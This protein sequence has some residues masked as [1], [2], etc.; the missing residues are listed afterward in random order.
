MQTSRFDKAFVTHCDEN[1]I[2]I[3]D[4]M[5]STVKEYSNIPFIVYV[6]NSDKPVPNADKVVRLNCDIREGKQFIDAA[7]G[8]SIYVDRSSERVYD[9]I[10]KKPTVLIHALENFADHVVYI[11]GDSI[12]TPRIED[13]FGWTNDDYPMLT[14]S[15]DEFMMWGGKGNPFHHRYENSFDVEYSLETP[16][17]NLLN[18]DQKIN[19]W[20]GSNSYVQTGYISSVKSNLPFL[21]EWESLCNLEEIVNNC[22][23]YAPFHEETIVNVLLWKYQYK[24]RMP[25]V[26]V[27]AHSPERIDKTYLAPWHEWEHDDITL[28]RQNEPWFMLPGN[29]SDVKVF[30]GEKRPHVVDQIVEKIKLHNGISRPTI[31]YIAP[32]LSTGGM[33]Q[34]LLKRVEA[35]LK[36]NYDV[37]VVEFAN[38]S[39]QYVVQ[40]EK[41]KAILPANRLHLITEPLDT[42]EREDLLLHR[43]NQIKPH[44][45]HLEECPESFDV[46]NRMSDQC[47]AQ[48]YRQGRKWKVVETCHNI[49]MN[50]SGKRWAP[51]KYMLCTPHHAVDNFKASTIPNDVVTYPI[52]DLTTTPEM[53]R[54]AVLELGL[55]STK[56][57]VLNVGLWTPGKNQGQA[58]EVARQLHQ[59]H[60]GKFQFHFVGNQAPNFAEYWQPLMQDLPPNVKVWGERSDTNRFMQACPVMLFT[61]TWECSPITLRESIAHGQLLFANQL[62]QYHDQFSPWLQPLAE[63]TGAIANQLLTCLEPGRFDSLPQTPQDDAARFYSEHIT[64]YDDLLSDLGGNSENLQNSEIFFGENNKGDFDFQLDPE[65]ENKE[66]IP[67]NLALRL[68]HESQLCLHVDYL[69]AGEWEAQ[70]WLRGQLMYSADIHKGTYH[71]AGPKW[72]QTGWRVRI[73]RKGQLGWWIQPKQPKWFGIQLDSS[74]LGDTISWMGQLEWIM[75]QTDIERLSV[76]CH[77]PWMF[78]KVYY[79]QLGIEIAEDWGEAW[80]DQWQQLGVYQNEEEISPKLRHPQDWRQRGLGQIACD[81]VGIPYA[82]EKRPRLQPSWYLPAPRARKLVCIAEHSTARAKYWNHPTGWQDLVDRFKAIDWDVVYVSKEDCELEGV[83]KAPEDLRE[84]AQLMSAAGYF[85]GIS[86][87]L[88][89]LAWALGVKCCMISGFTWEWVEFDADVRILDKSGCSGCWHWAKFDRGDWM[90]CPQWKG[91]DR[92]FE[93]TK[94]IGAD[95]VWQELETAGWFNV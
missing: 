78:D 34:F 91:T 69:P 8:D 54:D 1:Y 14:Q 10:T 92:A 18:V 83:E 45:V 61:S 48:I 24:D 11:D 79:K 42:I 36:S 37:H 28:R 87:G 12:A 27:N 25:L 22:N 7:E 50:E 56:I 29:L 88:S 55:D 82:G 9:I 90:W 44:I 26:Y 17:C 95:K 13:L 62:P 35:M 74:S 81:L 68:V 76:R 2:G 57:N 38:Y 52:E 84:V 4:K 5:I 85:V 32:H 64:F 77:K 40:K 41:L 47:L 60:P 63:E 71:Q 67:A 19:R 3:V 16:L 59:T 21:K 73:A 39:D 46:G 70:F 80:P 75:E 23:H 58:I 49:W 33:P 65:Q 66:P 53:R 51:D 15:P 94:H 6:I 43:L 31:A 72:W 20:P 93:C 30:H 86:S 89:W